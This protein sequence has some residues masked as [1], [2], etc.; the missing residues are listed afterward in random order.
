MVRRA[1]TAGEWQ[2]PITVTYSLEGVTPSHRSGN[3]G[4]TNHFRQTQASNLLWLEIAGARKAGRKSA[5]LLGEVMVYC[6]PAIVLG[7]IR[8]P[9]WEAQPLPMPIGTRGH[10]GTSNLTCRLPAGSAS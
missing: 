9:D 1:L 3:R 7:S 5:E 8:H 2:V 10:S 6:K 4:R